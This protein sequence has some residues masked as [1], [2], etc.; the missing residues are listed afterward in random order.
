M[1]YLGD[2]LSRLAVCNAEWGADVAVDAA[3][4][5]P[6]TVDVTAFRLPPRR[7]AS[8]DLPLIYADP[9]SYDEQDLAATLDVG[10]F[11]FNM[12]VLVALAEKQKTDADQIGEKVNQAAYLQSAALEYYLAHR[13]LE[14]TAD[15][16]GLDFVTD[17][18][19]RMSRVGVIVTPFGEYVGFVLTLA[20]NTI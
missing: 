13:Q 11:T 16:A 4:P 9:P 3:V 12:P 19:L 8:A 5:T 14:T 2:L 15:P 1:S 7:I 6:T 18:K 20:I 17:T 10:T